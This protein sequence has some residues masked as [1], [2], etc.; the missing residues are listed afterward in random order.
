M[1]H[2][3]TNKVNETKVGMLTHEYELFSMQ[4]KESIF[5]MYNHFTTII[6]NLKGLGNTYANKKLVKKILNS[7]LKSW[8]AKVNAIEESKDPNTFPLNELV[9]SLLTYE[10]KVK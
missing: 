3:G 4:S 2:E 5:E 7:L 1:I 9:G 6:T 10:M 8:K